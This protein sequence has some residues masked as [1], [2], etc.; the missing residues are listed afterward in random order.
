[1][2]LSV[3]ISAYNLAGIIEKTLRSFLRQTN[4]QF[5][6]IVVDDGSTDRTYEKAKQILKE[7]KGNCKIIKKENGGVGSGRNR[8]LMEAEGEYVLFFDGDDYVADDLVENLYKLPEASDVVCWAYNTV[9]ENG[10]ASTEYFEAYKHIKKVMTGKEAL[11]SIF[12]DEAMWVWTGSAVYRR[13]LLT[14]NGLN[15]TE[16]CINGEDQEFSIKALSRADN[17]VF[18]NK[19]LS[20]YVQRKG[21]ITLSSD[22]RKF[23]VID[24]LRRSAAYLFEQNDEDL[25]KIGRIILNREIIKNYLISFDTCAAGYDTRSV[26]N[27]IDKLYPGLN[28]D[29]KEIMRTYRLKDDSIAAKSRLFLISPKLY[30]EAL[31]IKRKVVSGKAGKRK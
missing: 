20:F 25:A 27:K 22:I 28:A 12:T 4:R 15:Y 9:N 2:K 7:F 17:V 21:S 1:M 5:E 18:I 29:I 16:G 14:L 26:L 10:E 8:G 13:D 6:L 24:A 11:K 30:M 23:D 3:I 19:V 31:Y